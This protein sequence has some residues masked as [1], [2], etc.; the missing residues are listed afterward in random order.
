MSGPELAVIGAEVAKLA[1]DAVRGA[2]KV[3]RQLKGTQATLT[4]N[5]DVLETLVAT[6]SLIKNE[7]GLQTASVTQVL[8]SITK[9]AGEFRT[10]LDGRAKAQDA[11]LARRT[12]HAVFS[13]DHDDKELESLLR[14]LGDAR[15]DLHTRLSLV[16][17][18][19]QRD[20]QGR[21][22]AMVPQLEHMAKELHDSLGVQLH[23]WKRLEP[24]LAAVSAGTG[25]D[26]RIIS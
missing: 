3:Y 20:T 7:S 15:Q 10:H 21:V 23:I 12:A 2:L 16:L 18:S 13:G 5:N 26:I 14:R 8:E 11:K 19:V 1:L 6:I 9:I 22:I 24:R 17:F 25:T 4:L